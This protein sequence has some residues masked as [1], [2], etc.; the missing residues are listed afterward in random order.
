MTCIRLLEILPVLA[1]RL[2]RNPGTV[3]KSIPDLSWLQDLMDWGGSSL[4]VV[5]RYW[6]QSLTSLLSLLKKSCGKISAF[7]IKAIENLL[8]SGE[9]YSFYFVFSQV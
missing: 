9:I 3:I 7:A 2:F 4:P 8:S 5:F 6:K 1:E